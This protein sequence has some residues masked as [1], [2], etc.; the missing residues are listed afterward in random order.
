[1]F[2]ILALWRL[3]QKDFEFK[4][5]LG[6]TVIPHL[7]KKKKL[8]SMIAHACIL[9]IQEPESRRI[10]VQ[11]QPKQKVSETP[12]LTNKKVGIVVCACHPS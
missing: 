6:Y 12:I 8:L 4:P 10:V 2:V 1:M 3:R 7:K 11:G 5:S 9:A